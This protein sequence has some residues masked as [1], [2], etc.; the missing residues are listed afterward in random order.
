MRDIK[1]RAIA[2]VDNKWKYGS[3]IIYSDTSV[4]IQSEETGLTYPC[5]D[6]TLSQYTGM[7]DK[8]GIS[9]YEG[10][11]VTQ[12]FGAKPAVV[13]WGFTASD[14]HDTA[15]GYQDVSHQEIIGNTYEN[16]ELLAPRKSEDK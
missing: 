8:H 11:I 4:S 16:K 14:D 10:D 15:I 9:I 6:H 2:Q 3:A 7:E 13:E 1:F 5:I 12:M